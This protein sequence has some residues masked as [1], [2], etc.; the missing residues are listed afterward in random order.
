MSECE[1]RPVRVGRID[2]TACEACAQVEWGSITGPVDP[3]E[4]LMALFGNFEM[5]GQLEAL[6]APAPRVIVYRP[7]SMRKR[8]NL[9]AFP[10]RVWLQTAPDL[11]MS[12]DGET[13]LLA[14]TRQIVFENLTRRRA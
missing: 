4:A 5:V 7:P 13:L 3:A 12:H 2:V 14:P 10:R 9:D 11:W 8:A 1:H 6:G